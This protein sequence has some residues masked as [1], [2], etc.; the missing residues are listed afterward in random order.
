MGEEKTRRKEIVEM[1]KSLTINAL[2]SGIKTVLQIIFPLI[3]FPY[4]SN[5]LQ[6]D[7][8][9]KVN[10][11]NSVCGYFLLF[12][13]LGISSYAVREGSRYVNDREK[14]SAFASEMF[15]INMIS[16]ALTYAALV[17]T[18]I[19]WTKLHAYTDLMLVL[20]LQI[21]FTT[22][23]TE[24]VFTIFEEYTYITVRGIIFQIASI[25]MMFVFV[26][27]QDDYCAYAG[28][29]VFAAAGTNILNFFRA[30][31]YCTIRLTTKIDWK[32]HLK[33]ILLIFASSFAITIYV[34]S[35][36]TILGV[37]ASDYHVGIYT[38]ATK[39]YTMVKSVL[40][41]ILLVSVPRLSRYAGTQDRVNFERLFNKVFEAMI[42]TVLPVV[43]GLFALSREVILF[44]SSESYLDAVMSL[45]ILSV[46][47]I[48]SLFG[49]LY[50]TCVL[51]PWK[52]EG[53]F[54]IATLVSAALNVALNI[55]LIPQ[56]KENA[57]A[58]TTLLAELC[59][60]VLCIYYSKGLV[61]VEF[62]G[63]TVASVAC[64]CVGI[65]AVCT[66]VKALTLPNIVCIL[67]AVLGS[68]VVYGVIMIGMKNPLVL[69]YL[70]KIKH[71]LAK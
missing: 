12:A 1:K 46:A 58:F 3:T 16:T 15:T 70:D 53:Q 68:V 10:F 50:N 54:L 44:I 45:R 52:R 32:K 24:W 64:G 8:L 41:S 48:V 35:D 20:S 57:A 66:A 39:I 9:G 38:V 51:V 67:A 43:V 33:P 31:R 42:L 4:I 49:W 27:T 47:L 71:K 65:V 23:G 59:S 62:E 30:R 26:K 40:A 7:N 56:F 61:K 11:A 13:G 36:V 17:V 60:M 2:M 22:V 37:L 69:E 21:F 6:V 5:V 28:I 63:Q 19:F 29:T 55:L 25:L 18:M 14:L 34:N